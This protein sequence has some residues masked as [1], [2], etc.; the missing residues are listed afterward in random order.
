[1]TSAIMTAQD[2]SGNVSEIEEIDEQK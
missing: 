2:V 1:M